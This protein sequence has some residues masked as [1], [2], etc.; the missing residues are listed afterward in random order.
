MHSLTALRIDSALFAQLPLA[1]TTL[2]RLPHPPHFR[3]YVD[4]PLPFDVML[5]DEASMIDLPL[6]VKL[7]E[8]VAD[9]ARLVRPGV[10]SRVRKPIVTYL[11]FFLLYGNFLEILDMSDLANPSAELPRPPETSWS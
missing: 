10:D 6:M 9:G 11:I 8:A 2:H 4:N 5:A 3:H 7:D 1:G